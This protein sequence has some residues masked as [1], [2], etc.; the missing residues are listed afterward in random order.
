[1]ELTKQLLRPSYSVLLIVQMMESFEGNPICGLSLNRD[2]KGFRR[3]L[4]KDLD[5][6]FLISALH[7]EQRRRRNAPFYLNQ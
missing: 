3:F 1:M 5:F 7:R 6:S 4:S 2:R